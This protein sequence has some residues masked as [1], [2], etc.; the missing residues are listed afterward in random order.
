M[1]LRICFIWMSLSCTVLVSQETLEKEFNNLLNDKD[2]ENAHI[3]FSVTNTKNQQPIYQYQH[4]KWFSTASSLKLLTTASALECLG[5]NYKFKTSIF[6][7]ADIV[8]G[9]LRGDLIIKGTGDPTFASIRYQKNLKDILSQIVA[10][11]KSKNIKTITGNIT[12]DISSFEINPLSPKTYWLDL[13]NYY[14][15]AVWPINIDENIYRVTFS[16]TKQIGDSTT[17]LKIDPFLNLRL[18]NKVTIAGK[19]DEAYIYCAPY[20][21]YGF[22]KGTLPP[23]TEPYT[24]KGAI[25]NPLEYFGAELLKTL[26]ENNIVT[27]GHVAYQS[28]TIVPKTLIWESQSPPL[29]EIVAQTNLFSINIYAEA[30]LRAIALEKTGMA[31]NEYGIKIIQSFV[32]S[33]QLD[34]TQL[35]I[36]DGSGISPANMCSP[37]LMSAF[38][39]NI[40]QKPWFPLFYNSLSSSGGNGTLSNMGKGTLLEG[41]LRAKSGNMD[42]ISSYAGYITTKNGTMLSFAIFINNFKAD[43]AVIKKKIERLLLRVSEL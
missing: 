10:G 34:S 7:S 22:V 24:I 12:F 16:R 21:N 11:L 4:K 38:L 25:P 19:T 6:T 9:V 27:T 36:C 26:L 20:S 15:G 29:S 39:S 40:T 31:L 14:G 2:L 33:L 8:S 3:G 30:L 32:N 37:N 23:S 5:E 1:I 13:G 42:G 43:N 41:N 35:N 17:I 28:K 18:D